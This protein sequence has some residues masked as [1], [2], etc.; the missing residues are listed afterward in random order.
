[1]KLKE[2][3]VILQKMD[4]QKP[5]IDFD[6]VHYPNGYGMEIRGIW[7]DSEREMVIIT[8]TDQEED[9]CD[10]YQKMT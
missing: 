8:A 4:S 10:Y 7:Y 5:N 2:V 6:F 9:F 3:I 1:M